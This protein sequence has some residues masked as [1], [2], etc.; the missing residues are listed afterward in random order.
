MIS[1]L[2]NLAVILHSLLVLGNHRA[3]YTLYRDCGDY[4]N[5]YSAD[6]CKGLG[7][8]EDFIISCPGFYFWFAMWYIL[9]PSFMNL[10]AF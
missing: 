3:D 4:F 1:I 7:Q 2:Q 5:Q 10:K 9:F 8:S 6:I